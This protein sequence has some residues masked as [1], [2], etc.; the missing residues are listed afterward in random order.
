ME[1]SHV[2]IDSVRAS[3]DGHEFHEAWVA[4]KSLGLLLPRNEFVG[5]AIEG[6]S[7]SDQVSKD[8]TEIADAVLY[9][10]REASF[11]HS[12]RV[13]VVQVKY[14]KA[15]ELKPFRAADAKKTIGKFASWTAPCASGWSESLPGRFLTDESMTP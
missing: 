9:Y 15:A 13:I 8:A 5:L 12:T 3:R 11:E 1:K 2:R 4:R 7:P 10:G 14:S 6:F